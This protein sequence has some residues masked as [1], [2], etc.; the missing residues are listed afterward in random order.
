MRPDL[1]CQLLANDSVGD[2]ALVDAGNHRC[3]SVCVCCFLGS[4]RHFLL[5]GRTWS[6]DTAR[7]NL[8]CNPQRVHA[9]INAISTL[10]IILSML[11]LLG[12]SRFYRFGGRRLMA[13]VT[14]QNLSKN[15]VVRLHWIRSPLNLRMENS[16]RYWAPP[17]V[18]KPLCYA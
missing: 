18:A 1:W 14:V 3:S 12:V 2:R 10:V 15:L 6:H 13:S 17:E 16:L 11:L 9:E 7:G 8:H 4:I 5:S